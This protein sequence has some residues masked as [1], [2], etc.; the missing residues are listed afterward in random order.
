MSTVSSGTEHRFS[1]R[2]DLSVKEVRLAKECAFKGPVS[3]LN[4][5]L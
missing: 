4:D 3:W 1:V 2:G 5:W